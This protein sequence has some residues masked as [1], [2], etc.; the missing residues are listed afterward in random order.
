MS[1]EL[2]NEVE[3]FLADTDERL[4]TADRK[5]VYG[6]FTFEEMRATYGDEWA[7]DFLRQFS[8]IHKGNHGEEA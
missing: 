4:W 2:L 3:K 5:P 7:D 1:D 8:E 6:T